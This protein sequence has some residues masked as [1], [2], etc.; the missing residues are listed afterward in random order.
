MKK[1]TKIIVLSSLVFLLT[2]C[3]EEILDKTPLDAYSDA[4]IWTDPALASLYLNDCYNR[5]GHGF[6]NECMEGSITDE[7]FASR[8][9]RIV[10]YLLGT[11]TPDNID[12]LGG[13]QNFLMHARWN[14]AF[15]NIQRINVFLDNIDKV[16]ENYQEPEKSSIKAKTDL[17]KGEA[18]FLR[19]FM[20]HRLVKIYGGVPLFEKPN[21]LGDDYSAMIRSTF[22][23]T[24]NFIVKDCND[25]SQLLAIKSN[26]EMGRATK[27]AAFALKSRILL[28]AASDLTADGTA[29]SEFVGY[30]NPNRTALWTAA[31]DAAKVLIDLGTNKLV[32][33]GAPDKKAVATNYFGMFKTYNLS[34]PEVIWG[35][36]FVQSVGATQRVNQWNGPNGVDCWGSF[37]P[38]NHMVDSY[39]MEDGSKFFD[40]FTINNDKQYTNTSSVFKSKNPYYNR[41]P[42]FY[43]CVLYDSV[44]WQPRTVPS[45]AARDPLGIYDRRTRRTM[46]SDGTYTEVFGIDTRKDPYFPDGGVYGGYITKK[47][48]D[49]KSIGK[50]E[51]NQNIWIYFRYAEILLNYA[52]ACL[53]L[54]DEATATQYINMIRNRVALPNFD[55]DITPAL[56]HERKIELFAEESRFYDIRRWKVLEE[57][58]SKIHY[59][60]EIIEVKNID[61][62]VTTKWQLEAATQ[63][64]NK[65]IKSMYWIPISVDEIKKAPQLVQ[66]PGF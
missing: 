20:Y 49:D 13:D 24:V 22:E 21:E 47:F 3:L 60:T 2:S 57:S 31:R 40:H 10:P 62:T 41:E 55:G 5:V 61:G 38:L 43:A 36:M 25:A 53:E 46:K 64:Q 65:P 50:T 56:R 12:V 44:V 58:L 54:G 1:I 19:A 7:T 30:A 52:E 32:D 59:N 18:L 16:A 8:G 15:N 63:P 39:E 26:T 23:E 51:N 33:L 9:F 48:M 28:F 34:S 14:P 6:R 11:L 37:G 4:I 17:L 42:R 35:K 27:E 29:E 45:L 66:N